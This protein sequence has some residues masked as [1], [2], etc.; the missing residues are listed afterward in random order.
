MQKCSEC[1]AIFPDGTAGYVPYH[2]VEA[3]NSM[4]PRAIESGVAVKVY[5]IEFPGDQENQ[6]AFFL[7]A[8]SFESAAKQ[9]GQA[10][11]DYRDNGDAVLEGGAIMWEAVEFSQQR[12]LLPQPAPLVSVERSR[13]MPLYGPSWPGRSGDSQ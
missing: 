11:E 2:F 8:E 3:T 6:Q 10:I 13:L 7:F 5:V 12:V 4:C 9:C 1:G